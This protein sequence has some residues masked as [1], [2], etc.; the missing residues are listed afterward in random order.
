[1]DENEKTLEQFKKDYAV[2]QKQYD[3]PGFEELNREFSIEKMYEIET[4]NLLR[5]VRRFVTDRV[6]NYSRFVEML[7]NP[8]NAP[9]Y[10][11][12]LIK[13]FSE[14]DKKILSEIHSKFVKHEI[15]YLIVEL[16]FDNKKEKEILKSA[17]ELWLEMKDKILPI[18]NKAEE[19]VDKKSES[20]SKGYFG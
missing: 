1:M 19:N 3:L 4:D 5:E 16:E 15:K 7:L 2:I 20:N 9:M 11:F 10:V 14:D 18:L 8:S 13:T 17:Y 6:Y 12:S